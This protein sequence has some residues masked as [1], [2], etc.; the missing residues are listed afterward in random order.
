M[1]HKGEPRKAADHFSNTAI[2]LTEAGMAE[3]LTL[4]T[5]SCKNCYRCIRQCPVKSIRFENNQAHILG[6]ECILCGHCFVACPQN[7]KEIRND[8]EAVQALI[9]GGSPV[10]ASLAPSFTANYGGLGIDGMKGALQQL[11]FA[12]AEETAVGAAIVKRQYDVMLKDESQDVIISSCC[13]SVNLLI[14]KYYPAASAMLA[15]V[16]SPMLAHGMD[17]KRRHPG[18]RTVFIGPCIAKKD[19]AESYSALVDGTLTFTELSSWLEQN[20]ISL[21]N[22]PR[23]QAKVEAPQGKIDSKRGLTRF[24]PTAG[25]ILRSMAKENPRYAYFFVDGIDNCIRSIEDLLRGKPEKCFVEM[26]ACAGSCLGGPVMERK[27]PVRDYIALSRYAGEEDF[28]TAPYPAGE[29]DRKFTA[30]AIRPIHLGAEA[31][32]EVLRKLGKTKPEHELNCGTCGYNTCREKARAVLEGKATLTM[33]LPYLKERAESFS[34][35]IIAN[36]PDG[37]IVLNENLEVQ[38]INAAACRVFNISPQDILG[39]QVVRVLDPVPFIEVCRQE[40]NRHDQRMYLADY[41]KYIDQTVIYDK[42]YH[43]IIGIMRDI[44]EDAERKAEKEEFNRK[45]IE[46]TNKVIEKQMRAVHEIASLLGETTA[47]TKVALTKLKES[48]SND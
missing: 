31:I 8:L 46:I 13:H 2:T 42:N 14:Q 37:I 28:E 35:T 36:T 48:L 19:E 38:Q 41:K 7:A 33:C 17:I 25:G 27:D 24:F 15:P 9:A 47:E 44:T 1:I 12:G 4:K 34:D 21:H 29:L 5:S 18:A 45:T 26:S 40:K 43:I 23:R 32:E 39:D 10:Y 11:G 20:N 6:E 30:P 3:L 16:L 22:P